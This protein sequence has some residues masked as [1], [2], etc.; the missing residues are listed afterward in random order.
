M[1]GYATTGGVIG[2]IGC[3][4]Y[5]ETVREVYIN[6][7][8]CASIFNDVSIVEGEMKIGLD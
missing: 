7:N 6:G 1:T 4:E 2:H 5:G 3:G 8:T